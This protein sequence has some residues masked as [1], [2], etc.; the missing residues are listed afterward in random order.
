MSAKQL[1]PQESD[2]QG[3][4]GRNQAL[5]M[6]TDN[7]VRQTYYRFL[8]QKLAERKPVD[9]YRESMR[10]RTHLKSTSV[11]SPKITLG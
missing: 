7:V 5:N 4:G 6:S 1:L 11:N 10:H 2:Y 3:G 9:L 8:D